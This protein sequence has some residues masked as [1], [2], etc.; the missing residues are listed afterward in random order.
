MSLNDTVSAQRIH[1]GFFGV[2]NVGKSSLVNRIT[3]QEVSTV[4]DV[5]GTTTDNVQ[6]AMEILPL[7]PVLI[8]DTPGFDDEGELGEKRVKNTKKVLNNCDIAILVTEATRELNSVEDEL[9]NIFNQ[10]EI[11]YI[12][13]KNKVDELETEF[14]NDSNIAYKSS[15]KDIGINEL[16]EMIGKLNNKKGNNPL[17]GDLIK[18]QDTVILVTPIDDSAPKGR[19]ILPQQQVLRDVL[20]HGGISIVVKDTE[21]ETA[22]RTLKKSP[23]L[24]ITDSQVFSKVN[25][26]VPENVRLTSFSILMSR[27]KGYLK[28]A[29]DGIRKIKE[30]KDGDSILISEGCTHHRQCEDIGTVKIPNLLKKFTGKDLK[31]EWSSG[32]SFPEDLSKYSLVIHCGGCTLNENEL[33][34]RMN[35]AKE[36]NIPFTN[37]GIAIAYMNGILDRCI[38]FLPEIE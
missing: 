19:I 24:V 20:D 25:L 7:G 36:Q 12:I 23:S 6:K 10:R 38:K 1:I 13:V 30:L 14:E 15:T 31:L 9:I 33:K 26:I 32:N 11:P 28:T 21:L 5:K 8:I 18:P 2:R 29:V 35:L 17:I 27:Y 22:L 34:H 4:S 37:Y 16:K 3:N